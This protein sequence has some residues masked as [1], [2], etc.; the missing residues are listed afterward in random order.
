MRN[1]VV[2]VFG[3]TGFIGRQLIQRLGQ[4]GTALRVVTRDPDRAGFLRPMG[5]VGQIAL[6]PYAEDEAGLR[7]LIEGASG[8]VNLLGILHERRRGDFDHVHRDMAERIA[9]T[10]A[11]FGV[12]R[13]VHLSAIGADPAGEALYAK[14]KGEGEAAVLAAFPSATILR[15][16]IVFGPGDGFFTR[17]ARMSMLSPFLPL[18][19]G[20]RTRFQP[21]YV[22]DVADSIVLALEND[23]L[24]GQTFELGGP[25]VASFEELLRYILKVLNRR[26]LLLPLPGWLAALQARLVEWLPNPPL[27]RDQLLLLKRDNVVGGALPG[28]ADLG[29]HPTP[30]E[31]IVPGYIRPFGLP[32]RLPSLA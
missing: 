8:V 31:A 1:E 7:L 17:F 25:R 28:L 20:G 27:T 10:A 13:L 3:G 6:V 4:R 9:K 21:V 16:S 19:D 30:F 26:R 11:G 18:I 5:D 22:G 15:P 32:R 29:I 14:S 23:G 12:R 2:T 24:G